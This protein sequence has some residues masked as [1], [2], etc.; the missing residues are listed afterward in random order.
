MKQLSE[1]EVLTA[2]Q[3]NTPDG[4][5]LRAERGQMIIEVI[6]QR[7]VRTQLNAMQ[8][9]TDMKRRSSGAMVNARAKFRLKMYS[10][11]LLPYF[12]TGEPKETSIENGTSH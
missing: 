11:R 2:L 7:F 10:F 4:T 8:Y 1:L 5:R 9:V 3:S 12:Y 6:A